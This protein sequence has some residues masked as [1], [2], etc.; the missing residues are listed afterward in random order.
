MA[1]KPIKTPSAQELDVQIPDSRESAVQ[2]AAE[3]LSTQLRSKKGKQKGFKATA[4]KRL[5]LDVPVADQSAAAAAELARDILRALPSDVAKQLTV[6]FADVDAALLASDMLD[7]EVAQL[8]DDA[9]SLTGDLMVVAPT[10]E[11]VGDVKRLLSGWR[12]R[13]VVVLNAEW[14]PELPSE[15]D[16]AFTATFE[17]VYSFMPLAIKAFIVT[18]E[19]AVYKRVRRGSPSASPWLIFKSE[20]GEMRCIGRQQRRPL[21]RDLESAIAAASAAKSP[22]AKGMQMLKK[23]TTKK[24]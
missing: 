9:S 16:T 8:D 18:I 2:Q 23:I 7:N 21:T 13:A 12:G 14:P 10:V 4:T 6:V 5:A 1:A 11:Q 3:A 17:H 20:G 19:G 22:V 15:E 24:T